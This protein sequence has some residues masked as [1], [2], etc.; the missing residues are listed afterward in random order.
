M[1]HIILKQSILFG[2]IFFISGCQ[3]LPMIGPAE[4]YQPIYRTESVDYD[5]NTQSRIRIYHQWSNTNLYENT[6]C[7][8]WGKTKTKNLFRSFAT[9]M[10]KGESV[11]IGI[12][13]TEKSTSVLN[14][15]QKGWGPKLTFTE[16]V[17]TAN[18][19]FV[20]DARRVE[21]TGSY[22]CNI[23][24][25][26]IPKAG[27]SYEAE[28]NEN[29]NSCSLQLREISKTQINTVHTSQNINGLRHCF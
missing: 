19:P 16:H 26:F 1:H 10:P 9:S 22:T 4:D 3:G 11:I 21:A 7:E 29:G 23:A 5:S 13:Q 2:S 27:T 6:S 17:I 8:A 25:S 14:T 15:P 28:Y 20:I 18:Q 12:P 24:G